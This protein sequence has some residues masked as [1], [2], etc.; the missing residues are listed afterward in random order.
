[1]PAFCF[2]YQALGIRGDTPTAPIETRDRLAVSFG[3]GEAREC[4]VPPLTHRPAAVTT[5]SPT[6]L[7]LASFVTCAPPGWPRRSNRCTSR[8]SVSLGITD[9]HALGSSGVSDTRQ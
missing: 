1:M 8:Q 4:P 7:M 9:T 5:D 3:Q 2:R 6:A